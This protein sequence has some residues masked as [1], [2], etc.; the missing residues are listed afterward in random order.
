MGIKQIMNKIIKIF[1]IVKNEFNKQKGIRKNNEIFIDIFLSFL[2]QEI[3]SIIQILTFI[4]FTNFLIKNIYFNIIFAIFIIFL[5]DLYLSEK[6]FIFLKKQVTDPFSKINI[7]SRVNIKKIDT[8]L[9]TKKI[10]IYF[11]IIEI[12]FV[13]IIFMI[14]FILIKK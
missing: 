1:K 10:I 3:P 13:L 11:R 9:L 8:N 5:L 4:G 6:L 12:I 14:N 2:S 7:F